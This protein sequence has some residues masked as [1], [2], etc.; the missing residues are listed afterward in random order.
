MAVPRFKAK[1]REACAKHAAGYRYYV[2]TQNNRGRPRYAKNAATARKMASAPGAKM[3]R[4]VAS[5]K[6]CRRR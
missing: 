6:H 3:Y 4:M 5:K 2:T 1:S